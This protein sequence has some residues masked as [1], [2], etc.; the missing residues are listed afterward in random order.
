MG[1]G[2]AEVTARLVI[3]QDGERHRVTISKVG[4]LTSSKLKADAE[5][6]V[7]IELCLT[8]CADPKCDN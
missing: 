4:H 6:K 7:L 5:Y 3:D 1:G 2:E 8:I